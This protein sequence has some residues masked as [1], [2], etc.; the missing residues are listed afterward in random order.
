MSPTDQR[1]LA[2]IMFTDMVG[3]SA[4]SQRDEARALE[5]LEEH[6][7]LIRAVSPRHGGREVKTIGDGFLLAF[8]SALSAVEAAVE[9][10]QGLHERNQRVPGNREVKIRIGIHVG[11]VVISDGDI[12]GDGVNIASRL[13]PLAAPGGICVSNA[14]FEQVQ[15]KLSHAWRALGAAELKHIKLPMTVFEVVLPWN[16]ESA[17][18]PEASRRPAAR[19]WTPYPNSIAV[20]PFL[21][22]SQ[23]KD[24]EYFSDGISEE[25]LNLLAK[26]P[27]LHVISRSSA[28]S[29]KGKSL[30][31]PELARRLKVAHVLEGSVRKSGNRLR[32]TAQ[33]IDALADKHLW[34]E[35]YD[36]SLDDIF[37]VQ[38]EIAA[39]VVAQ[40]KIVILGPGPRSKSI[41]P[42]AHALFLQGR[43]RARV[44]TRD[45]FDASIALFKRALDID[46]EYAACWDGLAQNYINQV[47]GGLRPAAEGRRL[48]LEA[49]TR[50]IA[51]EPELASAHA[52]LGSIAA[53]FDDDLAAGALHF[54]RA[55][56]LEP[57]NSTI[58]GNAAS[59]A[60]LLGRLD[61]AIALQAYTN[62]RDPLNG[63]GRQNLGIYYLWA[64]RLS[65]ALTEFRAALEISPGRLYANSYV[66]DALRLGGDLTGALAA[67]LQEPDEE[68]RL[69]GLAKVYDALGDRKRSDAALA[70]LTQKGYAYGN[71][72][73][74]RGELDRAFACLD[75]VAANANLR[76]TNLLIDS[77]FA[78]LRGD[79]RWLPFLRRIGKSPEQLAAMKFDVKVPEG[80]DA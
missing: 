45:G 20:L 7:E 12:H 13:E 57:T 80:W 24:Q 70:E 5:L 15:N 48:A 77:D 34:S 2:A 27:A 8:S 28:F 79:S 18:A 33:L 21:D 66:A 9:I 19:A 73:A 54:E 6:R 62:A 47:R 46:P 60:A 69:A 10:Q 59:L 72:L 26:I 53:Q 38:D 75:E 23:A 67:G 22:L 50:A 39:A 78:N 52:R 36:R 35:N 65:E 3:F 74:C 49:A 55:L 76:G 42:G 37:A 1:K 41:H 25:L 51:L 61:M 44:F 4:M 56:A 11:D 63:I 64:D 43:E 29:F 14:V 40:L 58:I 32:I 16:A 31:I 17:P 71:V 30:E 68:S